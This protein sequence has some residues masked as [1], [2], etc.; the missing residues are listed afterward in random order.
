MAHVLVVD[1][2]DVIRETLRELF[3]GTYQCQVASTAEEAL[4]TLQ[5]QAAKAVSIGSGGGEREARG[6]APRVNSRRRSREIRCSSGSPD[7]DLAH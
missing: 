5:A 1:D 7:V 2:D 3:E 4:H 6:R